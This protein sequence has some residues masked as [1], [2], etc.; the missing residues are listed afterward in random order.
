MNL[1]DSKEFFRLFWWPQDLEF[2]Q[3]GEEKFQ[4]FVNN[5]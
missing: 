4:N 5:F 2:L 3:G 1:K